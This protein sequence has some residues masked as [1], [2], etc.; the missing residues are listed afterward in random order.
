MQ[1]RP[2]GQ[3][4]PGQHGLQFT[5]LDGTSRPDEIESCLAQAQPG[6]HPSAHEF[7]SQFLLTLVLG[8]LPKLLTYISISTFSHSIPVI[9]P[10]VS[11]MQ[12]ETKLALEKLNAWVKSSRTLA[13]QKPYLACTSAASSSRTASILAMRTPGGT[14]T[15]GGGA[16]GG[17]RT[18]G[19]VDA[20][21]GMATCCC[22]HRAGGT[23]SAAKNTAAATAAA[24]SWLAAMW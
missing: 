23:S 17:S 21:G 19:E 24:R 16:D 4:K 9:C 15:S 1:V 22:W 20:G 18:G 8:F 5:A 12:S 3:K 11:S 2:R 10:C 13:M 14:P 7:W 6:W